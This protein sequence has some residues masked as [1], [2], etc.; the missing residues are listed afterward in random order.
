MNFKLLNTKLVIRVSLLITILVISFGCKKEET[1]YI[2]FHVFV[3]GKGIDCGD[4]FLLNFLD[5]IDELYQITAQEGWQTCYAYSLKEEFKV[6][7]KE[8]LVKIRKPTKD[9]LF[10][11]THLEPGY[12]W[13]TI[14]SAQEF[15]NE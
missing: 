3:Y 10:P 1:N 4:L 2:E 12:P 15:I 7:G 5:N 9:E 6:Q 13:V 8:L 11:C 14:V